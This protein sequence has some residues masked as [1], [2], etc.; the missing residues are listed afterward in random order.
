MMELVKIKK[1]GSVVTLNSLER[2]EISEKQFKN[3]IIKRLVYEMAENIIKNIYDLP[4][5]I[6]ESVDEYNGEKAYRLIMT[7]I[8]PEEIKRIND[9]LRA[10]EVEE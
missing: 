8:S 9:I 1:L 2:I 3:E 7:I 4:F 5:V 6:E 10:A